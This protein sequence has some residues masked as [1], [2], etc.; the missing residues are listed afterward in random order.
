MKKIQLGLLGLGRIGKMHAEIIHTH[1]S[2]IANISKV[3]TWDLSQEWMNKHR[4]S[5]AASSSEVI[6]SPDIDAIII[7]TPTN[8]HFEYTRLA[9]KAGKYVFCEKPGAQTIEEI[10]EL[11]LLEGIFGKFVQIGFNRRYDPNMM[12]IY[13]HIKNNKIGNIHNINIINYDPKRPDLNFVVNSGGL[14]VDFNIHDFD[15]IFF[16]SGSKIKQIQSLGTC[17]IQPE[18]SKYNDIDTAILNIELENGALATIL[19]SREAVYGYDQRVEVFG[20]KG[21]INM[22]NSIESNISISDAQGIKGDNP[23]PNFHIYYCLLN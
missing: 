15:S 23:Y 11:I 5:C 18:L 14:F 21:A 12:K 22:D 3:F 8:T 19:S 1:F 9:M 13:N 4:L 2:D 7:A 10:D 6:N 20:E 16:L 17:A